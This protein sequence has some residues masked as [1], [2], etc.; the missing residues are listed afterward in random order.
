M[1]TFLSVLL[2]LCLVAALP[3]A[4]QP[5]MRILSIDSTNMGGFYNFRFPIED[6]NRL[7]QAFGG[8]ELR[9]EFQPA[10]QLGWFPFP[11]VSASSPYG[12]YGCEII[13]TDNTTQEVVSRDTVFPEHM[14]EHAAIFAHG[15][16]ST[17][18][19][20][21]P[22]RQKELRTG[23]VVLPQLVQDAFGFTFDYAL[24]QWGGIYRSDTAYIYAGSANTNIA[25]SY[26]GTVTLGFD[27]TTS[28][29]M[30]KGYN[31]G[32]ALYDIEFL[33][34][35]M[36]TIS[37][38]YGP[39]TTSTVSVFDVPYLTVRVTN[40]VTY[41]RPLI[42]GDSL[43]VR[44]PNEVPHA[45]VPAPNKY[46]PWPRQADVPVGNYNFTAYAWVN[47]RQTD[48]FR[49][50]P[51]QA[52]VPVNTSY[53][54]NTGVP[55]GTQGRYYL[56]AMNNKGEIV[57]FVHVLVA[58]GAELILDYS[59][60]AGRKSVPR[61]IEKLETQPTKDFEVGDK[62][63]L[64][65]LGGALGFPLPS[66]SIVVRVDTTTTGVQQR[67][68]LQLS[69]TVS[70]HPVHHAAL[71]QYTVPQ[72]QNVTL[73]VFDQLGKRI[74]TLVNGKQ[75][76]GTHSVALGELHLQ[77]GMYMYRLQVGEQ[78]L[79]GTFLVIP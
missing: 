35:G 67:D 31:N 57:D 42:S 13:V 32:P 45:A 62:I 68:N 14:Y 60:K 10:W 78:F 4:A 73:T 61:L 41:K 58:S 3:L 55:V 38:K 75:D 26:A 72:A 46:A 56:S 37:L 39:H 22:S 69:A 29:L 47:G 48:G 34:G 7:R 54:P 52:A 21:P 27:T 40:N 5:T 64:A 9:I 12:G 59:N 50:R 43:T 25:R 77:R 33:P 1:K 66:A 23:T 70:P 65:T 53:P 19:G 71:L 30:P 51:N 79:H 74:Q 6:A 24:Q 2:L 36:E 8:H 49:D 17:G 28:G 11:Q 18:I 63:R 76:A 20:Y 15:D 44:Y 16:D